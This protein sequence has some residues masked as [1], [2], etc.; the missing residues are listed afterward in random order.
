M[1]WV[2]NLTRE[3]LVNTCPCQESSSISA[4]PVFSIF[5][6]S[7]FYTKVHVPFVH[8]CGKMKKYTF[9][10]HLINKKFKYKTPLI[11]EC[12]PIVHYYK[13]EKSMH[14]LIPF[15]NRLYHTHQALHRCW[16]C[17][18]HTVF[19]ETPSVPK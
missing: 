3:N 14:F 2:S 11:S 12:Q 7:F 19:H 5:I 10:F 17:T 18:S 8:R 9:A 6:F 1:G 16:L 15:S 13:G 4:Q